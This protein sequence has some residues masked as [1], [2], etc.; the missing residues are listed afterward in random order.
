MRFKATYGLCMVV[1]GLSACVVGASPLAPD[2]GSVSEHLCLWLRMPEIH[3]DPVAGI[4][5]D[6]SD[7]GN[8]ALADIDNFVGPTLS[9]GE[10]TVV[11]SHP[12]STVNFDTD[13][14]DMLRSIN[15]NGGA[16]LSELT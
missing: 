3:Y 7:K 11:F 6:L 1:M 5:T 10:N 12:F 13:V 9:S 4:W 15:L 16:G 2:S 14:A 8:D